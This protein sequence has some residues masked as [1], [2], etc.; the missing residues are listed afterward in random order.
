MANNSNS[1]AALLNQELVN[2]AFE[3]ARTDRGGILSTISM[4]GAVTPSN[5]HEHSWIDAYKGGN[6]VTVNGA[7]LAAATTLVT[8]TNAILRVGTLLE[9]GDEVIL[10]SAVASAT[11]CTVVRGFGG[12]TA[13]DIADDAVL[14]I[15]STGVQENSTGSDST[16]WRY[17]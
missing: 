8:D 3:I 13:A 11:S 2:A 15:D 12:T 16:I 5:G 9:N 1:L 4:G 6:V 10:V 17:E 14:T 7:I